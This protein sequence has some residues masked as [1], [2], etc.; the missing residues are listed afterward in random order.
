MMK[1]KLI[2]AVVIILVGA[3][4]LFWYFNS[5][6]SSSKNIELLIEKLFTT[7][8]ENLKSYYDGLEKAELPEQSLEQLIEDEFGVYFNDQELDSFTARYVYSETITSLSSDTDA[9]IKPQDI[10]VEYDDNDFKYTFNLIVDE[11]KYSISGNGRLNN[12]KIE[13]FSIDIPSIKI[14]E[15]IKGN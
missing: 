4:G 3:G 13:Y 6:S 14:I 11:K 8:N 15:E 12:D 10:K 9:K 2:I 1:K 7:P 5:S